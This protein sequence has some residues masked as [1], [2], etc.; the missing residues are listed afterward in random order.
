MGRECMVNISEQYFDGERPLYESR[1]L[2]LE[3][4]TIGEGESGLKECRNIQADHCTFNGMYVIW[5][6]ENVE[7]TN[8]LFAATDR[9]PLWYGRGL[10]L[11]DCRINAPKPLRELTDITIVRTRFKD[12]KDAFWFCRDGQLVDIRMKNTEYAF[13]YARNIEIHNAIVDTKDAFWESENVT[14]YDS[15][16]K[17]EYLGW[18]AKNLRLVRCRISGTQPLCY[19]ENLIIEDCSFA[20]DADLAFEKSSVQ[21]TIIGKV[22]SIKDPL[23]G[24]AIVEGDRCE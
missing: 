21:A 20:P 8:C 19:C 15:D 13:Q 14:V 6:F 7:C 17:G 22:T 2:R 12:T 9:A 24:S 3:R 5:E 16:I 11:S 4:V 1:D 10:R 23:P 18:Y